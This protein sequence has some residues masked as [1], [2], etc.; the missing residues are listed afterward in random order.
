MELLTMKVAG[1]CVLRSE[2]SATA[3][4]LRGS[5]DGARLVITKAVEVM[6]MLTVVVA[7]LDTKIPPAPGRRFKCM[8]MQPTLSF[9]MRTNWPE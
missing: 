5:R 4:A 7:V 6:V 2:P 9:H 3:E 1:S 8:I